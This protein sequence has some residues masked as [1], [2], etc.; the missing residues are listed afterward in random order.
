VPVEK[1]APLLAAALL[2]AATVLAYLTSFRGALVFDDI[3]G[4]AEN[5]TIRDLHRLDLLLVAVGPQGGTLSGRPLPNL[6]L[7]LNHAISGD[8]LWSYHATNLLIHLCTGLALFGLVRRTL[9][10]VRGT[11]AASST[12][13]AFCSALLWLLH[14]LQTE[15]V[16]YLV[17][18]VESLMALC[19][20]LALYCFVRG[21]ESPPRRRWQIGAFAACLAGMASKEVMAAAPLVVLLYDRTFLAGSW[22]AAWQQRKRQHLAL[23]GTWFVLGLLVFAS[24]GRGGTAGFGRA[25]SP[26]RYALTQ[27]EA[28]LG[29]LRLAFWPHPLVFDRRLPLTSGLADV[30]PQA[31]TLLALLAVTGWL[32]VRRPRAGFLAAAFFLI[33]APT[34]SVVPIDDAMVEHR[35]YL[36]LAAV[37][38]AVV[39]AL[40][41]RLGRTLAAISLAAAVAFGFVTA[42]RN[43][44][45]CSPLAF[46]TDVVRKAPENP[47]GHSNL[48]AYLLAA[49]RPAEA[50][51]ELETAL[52]LDPSYASAHY[53]LGLLLEQNHRDS[54]AVDAYSAAIRC[55]PRRADAHVNLGRVLD[56]L[57]RPA[58][59]AVHYEAA[60]QLD[61]DDAG[62]HASL[63]RVLLKLNRVGDAIR[64]LET[65][66][67]LEPDDSAAWCELARARQQHRDFAAA[68]QAAEHA[69]RLKPDYPE[70]FYVLGNLAAASEDFAAAISHFRRA[71]ELAPDYTAAR[72]NLANAL[73]V[74]GRT[75][76]AIAQ[77]REI[78]RA[79]PDDR[80]V[81]ENLTRALTSE[82]AAP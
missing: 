62:A 80:A 72:N 69:L 75:S 42:R 12:T 57:G 33:L 27:C 77:Y 65:A 24:G 20:V 11:A 10:R 59:A 1:R 14:P 17:Q 79:H 8:A 39:L 63:G 71:T 9:D 32:L 2:V 49:G 51:A 34:S 37:I 23:M 5:P 13:P 29:Y 50:Q 31:L 73:L 44:D 36:P 81:Q 26:W 60:L 82:R 41:A 74:S 56:R 7:A 68:R 19:F 21:N 67:E 22:R 38:A 43:L 15:S 52:A 30:W 3:P 16:T 76:E 28:L 47:R 46:W 58:E 54:E 70:A 55:D 6:T 18:R 45:Y 35:M 40:Q 61:P 48:G 53:N 78:L 25:V 66:C 4:I 64:H